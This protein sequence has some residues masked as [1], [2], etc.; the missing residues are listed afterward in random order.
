LTE[1]D[2]VSGANAYSGRSLS[3][4]APVFAVGA[5]DTIGEAALDTAMNTEERPT[6]S[7][8]AATKGFALAGTAL[9]FHS[10]TRLLTFELSGAHA[11]V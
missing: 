8:A 2:D 9:E 4:P 10:G 11:D 7:A 6:T 3:L 5:S 1:A